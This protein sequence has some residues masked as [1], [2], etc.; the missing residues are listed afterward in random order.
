[1]YFSTSLVTALRV[2]LVVLA[3]V[4]VPMKVAAQSLLGT[5][6]QSGDDSAAT[7]LPDPLTEEAANAL[8]SRLSDTEVR[9]LLLD[10][11]NAQAITAD[12]TE[13]GVSEF[14]YHA[15]T[16]AVA[17]IITSVKALPLLFSV[18]GRAFSN[19]YS[20]LGPDGLLKMFGFL[21]FAIAGALAVELIFRRVTRK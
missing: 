14:L 17:S 5:T 3:L 21:A 12:D 13:A 11:L 1:M 9:A 4:S 10:Q 19:F 6:S 15:T 8:I 2:L 7:T 18:Q 16:G 20:V